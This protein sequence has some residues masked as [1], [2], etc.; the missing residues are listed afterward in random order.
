MNF[1][2]E[3]R[4]S[5]GWEQRPYNFPSKILKLLPTERLVDC[6]FFFFEKKGAR[7]RLRIFHT[8][9]LMQMQFV[10]P[11]SVTID[12][13]KGGEGGHKSQV[14]KRAPLVLFHP[15]G[16]KTLFFFLL[17]SSS[18]L[19]YKYVLS[20][21]NFKLNDSARFDLPAKHTHTHHV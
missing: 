5:N 4:A 19:L 12:F 9:N 15:R 17:V 7:D 18:L 20:L 6:F 8:A 13:H 14:R 21:C 10:Y 1:S 3:Y 11:S 2:K 16:K